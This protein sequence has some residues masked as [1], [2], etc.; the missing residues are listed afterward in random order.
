MKEEIEKAYKRKDPSAVDHDGQKRLKIIT[1][2]EF[3]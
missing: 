3:S 1:D 2:A